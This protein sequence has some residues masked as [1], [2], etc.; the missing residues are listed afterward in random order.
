MKIKNKK[1]GMAKI[2][3]TKKCHSIQTVSMIKSNKE[4]DFSFP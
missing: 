2:L 4:R 1:N 3:S